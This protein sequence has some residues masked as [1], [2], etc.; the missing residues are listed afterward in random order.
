ME[1]FNI[2]LPNVDHIAIGSVVEELE[3]KGFNVDYKNSL[4]KNYSNQYT[5]QQV[6]DGENSVITQYI[7]KAS[8]PDCQFELKIKE[9]FSE[10]NMNNVSEIYE[11]ISCF[12]DSK[13]IGELKYSKKPDYDINQ[14]KDLFKVKE[15]RY[16][17][18]S[19]F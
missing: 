7:I 9:K 4:A 6:L 13:L 11:P 17:K 2:Y 12:S 10:I 18:L 3:N 14:I 19:L 15:E 5:L 16:D 1:K 8:S